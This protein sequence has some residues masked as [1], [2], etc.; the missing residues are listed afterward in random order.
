[1]IS[2]GGMRNVDRRE[3]SEIGFLIE[4]MTLRFLEDVLH[5]FFPEVIGRMATALFHSKEKGNSDSMENVP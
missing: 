3:G 4:T 1:M 2:A 5:S